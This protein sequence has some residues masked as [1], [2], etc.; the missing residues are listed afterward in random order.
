MKRNFVTMYGDE[1][2]LDLSWRLFC[3]VY[4]NLITKK[5]FDKNP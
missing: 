5:Y 2:K 3:N 1:C 4:K